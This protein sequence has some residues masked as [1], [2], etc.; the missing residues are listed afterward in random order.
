[1]RE[2]VTMNLIYQTFIERGIISFDDVLRS[3]KEEELMQKILDTVHRYAITRTAD[4]RYTTRVPDPTKPDGRRM[5]RRKSETELYH[6]LIGFY[7]LEDEAAEMTFGDLFGEWVEYKRQF[8][9]ASNR[10]RSLSPSTVRRYERDYMKY[11]QKSPLNAL[12]LKDLTTPRLTSILTQII[13]QNDMPERCASNVIGY[14]REAFSYAYRAEYIRRDVAATLDRTLLLSQCRYTPPK[15]S[16]ERV[17]TPNEFRSLYDAVRAHEAKHPTYMPDYAIELSLLTGMRVG[18]LAALEWSAVT[19]DAVHI[20]QAEQRM[21][22]ANK[23]CELVIGEPKNGRHRM[24]PL[25]DD[26]RELFRRISEVVHGRKEGFVFVQKSGKRY[27]AHDISCAVKRRASEAGIKKTSIH[28]IRRTVSSMLNTLLPT[29]AVA[30]LLGH[31]EIV[32]ERHYDYDVAANNEKISALQRVSPKVTKFEDFAA[33]K[34]EAESA[35]KS[36]F[37]ASN[38]S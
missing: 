38:F 3:S 19:N 25:T 22:Y 29:T 21:D 35:E 14:V 17:L 20:V 15:S 1:M 13:K 18:E 4:G 9:S 12:A 26:L 36:T 10:K 27:T 7:G 23:P 8:I 6:F 2:V 34:K 11:L 37:F 5:I 33:K 30:A 16:D 31:S 24:I 32:N 28:G